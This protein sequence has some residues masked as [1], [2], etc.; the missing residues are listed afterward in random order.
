[1]TDPTLIDELAELLREAGRVHHQAFAEVDGEDPEWP[2]WYAGYLLERFRALLGPGLTRSRLVCWL[3]L[4]AD[5]HARQAPDTEWA[6]YYAQFFAA[7]R[8]A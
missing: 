7:Q 2:L 8:P 4:A 3:V 1:M 6:A 5:D